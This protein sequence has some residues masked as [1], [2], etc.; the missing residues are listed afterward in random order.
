MCVYVKNDGNLQ[1]IIASACHKMRVY[2]KEDGNFTGHYS[3]S[4]L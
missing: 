4:L 1:V 2:V 3:L